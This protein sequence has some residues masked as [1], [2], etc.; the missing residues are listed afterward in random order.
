MMR[1]LIDEVFLDAF[2]GGDG[3][4]DD[5]FVS[6][7]TSLPEGMRLAFSTDTFTV[8]PRFFP[9]GGIGRL[10][11]CGTVNDVATSGAD[12]RYLSCAFIIEEGLPVDEL[13]RICAS[14][15]DAAREAD[16]SIVT[17][18]TKVVERGGCDGL[19]ISTAGVGFIPAGRLLS[20][21]RCQPGDTILLSGTIGDH[22]IALV[23]QREGLRFASDIASDC[24]PL[25]HLMAAV[26]DAAPGTR[27]FRDPTRGGIAAT[28][29][30]FAR[31]SRV[32]IEVVEDAVPVDE[33]VRGCCD[34]L[35]YDVFQ[36]A[37][38]GKVVAVVP[39]D[40]AEAA[41]KA[42]RSS[43][44]GEQAAIIGEV[45]ET[46]PIGPLVTVRTALGATRI[47]DELAGEQLPRIC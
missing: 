31:Q 8:S 12:V 27:C 22:G 2:G 43:A 11:V 18:D 10:A 3:R 34:M 40:E 29:N 44:Y 41:L 30:E 45:V 38:E 9:G 24:A 25:N 14:M 20:G 23:S 16:V 5:S 39:P 28:L 42:M 6:D 37:N 15:A 35:G 17:G 19:F 36:V 13:R 46:G 7:R 4:G 33:R 26:L 21:T 47:M 1:E 32:S